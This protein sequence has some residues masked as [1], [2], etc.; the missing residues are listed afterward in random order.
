MRVEHRVSLGKGTKFESPLSY[1]GEYDTPFQVTCT[2]CMAGLTYCMGLHG[3]NED[4]GN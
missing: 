3:V 4:P 1:A 2:V